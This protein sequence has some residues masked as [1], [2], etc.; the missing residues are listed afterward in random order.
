MMRIGRRARFTAALAMSFAL[1]ATMA[2]GSSTCPDEQATPTGPDQGRHRRCAR[3][4][5]DE[6]RAPQPVSAL[7]VYEEKLSAYLGAMC[8]RDEGSGG[9]SATNACAT[10]DRLPS[11][12]RPVGGQLYGTHAPWSSGTRR[13]VAWIKANRPEDGATPETAAPSPMARSS[14]RRCTPPPPLPAGARP[15]RCGRPRWGGGDGARPPSGAGRLVLGVFRLGRAPNPDYRLAGQ[16]AATTAIR[17]RALASTA[18][19]AMRRRRTIDVLCAQEFDGE[20]GDPLVFLRHFLSRLVMAEAAQRITAPA[21]P[22]T[23]RDG[24]RSRLQ[25]KRL[26]AVTPQLGPAP[27][28]PRIADALRDLRQRLGE[29]AER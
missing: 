8:H 26:R 20:P 25:S 24:H 12:R 3:R 29:G 6:V 28:T 17:Y 1:V 13:D 23:C 2:R 22:T 14:S 5:E 21:L 11:F 16:S 19:I 27:Q 15:V 7:D 10:Q 18:P 4:C 9:G